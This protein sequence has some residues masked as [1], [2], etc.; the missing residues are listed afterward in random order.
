[1]RFYLGTPGSVAQAQVVVDSEMPVL[2]SYAAASPWL[3]R[4]YLAAFTNGLLIDSGAY[5]ELNSGVEVDIGAYRDFVAEHGDKADACA[6]L[7]DIRGDWRRSMKNYEAIPATFP[8]FH[9]TD[10]PELLPELVAMAQGRNGWLGLGV[11]PPR[12]RKGRWLAETLARIP[13]GIHVH[14]WALGAY[15]QHRRMDSVDSTNWFRDAIEML[16]M[17][18]LRHLTPVE[19][20]RLVVLRYQRMQAPSEC[21]ASLPLF[22]ER[23]GAGA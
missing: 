2:V 12:Q 15:R 4:N 16:A 9:D 23:A 13:A 20:L 14:G 22:A 3:F 19:S 6:G 7:D 11:L 8:T 21:V 17:P 10:P 1:M 5:S 18:L